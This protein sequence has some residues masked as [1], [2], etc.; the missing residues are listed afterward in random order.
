MTSFH[1]FFVTSWNYSP[2]LRYG[3]P[4]R[5]I[6]FLLSPKYISFWRR[7]FWGWG[8]WIHPL[9][10]AVLDLWVF[11]IG[12]IFFSLSELLSCWLSSHLC[13]KM[14]KHEKCEKDNSLLRLFCLSGFFHVYYI[15][16]NLSEIYEEKNCLRYFRQNCLKFQ[17]SK[18]L[19][20]ILGMARKK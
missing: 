15:K 4:A 13:W 14:R 11:L 2:F 10:L 3:R 1:I 17:L 5:V 20:G 12:V 16:I 8:L 7:K 19:A 6:S 9:V 18:A